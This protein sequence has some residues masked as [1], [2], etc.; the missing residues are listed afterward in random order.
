MRSS[1]FYNK[2]QHIKPSASLTDSD[3]FAVQ[4]RVANML[5]LEI[6]SSYAGTHTHTDSYDVIRQSEKFV[7]DTPALQQNQK[8]SKMSKHFL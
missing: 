2:K 1:G 4:I 7:Y 5:A 8:T 6:H 3:A